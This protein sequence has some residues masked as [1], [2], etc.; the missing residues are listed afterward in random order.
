MIGVPR[1]LKTF[2]IYLGAALGIAGVFPAADAQAPGP[3]TAV[4]V[5]QFLANP[6]VSLPAGYQSA[7]ANDI[8]RELSV[9][10]PTVEIMREDTA[11]DEP[12]LMRISGTV[13][14][15]KLSSRAKKYLT[16]LGATE[17]RTEVRFADAGTGRVLA[18]HEFQSSADGLGRKIA[19]FCQAQRLLGSK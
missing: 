3:Y 9:E 18:I 1:I 17:L 6:G 19:K 10:D 14:Q 16:G 7:L 4:E 11:R 8:A 15:F 5:D 12:H 13:V 2:L